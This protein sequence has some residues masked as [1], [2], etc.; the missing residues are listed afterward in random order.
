MRPLILLCMLI[1]VCC[2]WTGSA[3]ASA[4]DNGEPVAAAS[5]NLISDGVVLGVADAANESVC[6]LGGCS[7]A[8]VTA[9]CQPVRRLWRAAPLRRGLRW[10]FRG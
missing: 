10:L 8:T 6:G 2:I 7:A 9:C 1:A 5:C 3:D 4:Y